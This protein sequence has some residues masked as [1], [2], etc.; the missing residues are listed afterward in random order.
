MMVIKLLVVSVD[1]STIK[2]TAAQ[3]RLVYIGV[4]VQDTPLMDPTFRLKIGHGMDC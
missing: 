3:F 1:H 2:E 4:R